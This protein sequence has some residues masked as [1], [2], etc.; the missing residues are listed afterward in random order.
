[1][2]E[3]ITMCRGYEMHKVCNLIDH[4]VLTCTSFAQARRV[5]SP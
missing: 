2:A 1:M 3:Y 4:I 5:S